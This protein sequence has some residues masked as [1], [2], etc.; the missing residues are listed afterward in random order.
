MGVESSFLLFLEIPSCA[1]VESKRVCN[2][3]KFILSSPEKA[4]Y[5]DHFPPQPMQVFRCLYVA[6]NFGTC[7][8]EHRPIQLEF[9][10]MLLG[11]VLCELG[12]HPRHASF[13]WRYALQ[14]GRN[15][16]ANLWKHLYD[17]M[18]LF[19]GESSV[20]SSSLWL[21]KLSSGPWVYA[22]TLGTVTGHICGFTGH[23]PGI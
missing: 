18:D 12:V 6:E 3:C 16:Q 22:P 8:S 15:E 13:L 19:T 5:R 14:N 23:R 7:S 10:S 4:F 17:I 2:L 21:S 11:L 9:Q 1:A 20:S